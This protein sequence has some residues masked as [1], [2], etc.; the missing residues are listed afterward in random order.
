[1]N[2]KIKTP[3]AELRA[4]L[5]TI[6][7]GRLKDV[8]VFGSYA[9]GD[10][11]PESDLDL[12]VVLDRIERYG[13]EVRRTGALVSEVALSHGLSISRVFV[14]ERDWRERDTVFLANAREEAIAA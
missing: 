6:Y 11:E 4:G 12:M 3:L 10:E 14:S 9:R 1:M 7:K 5:E 13:E 2:D 8:Y